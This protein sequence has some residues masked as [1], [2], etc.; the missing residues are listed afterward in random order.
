VAAKVLAGSHGDRKDGRNGAA[1]T[2]QRPS[3]TLLPMT[4]ASLAAP[5]SRTLS[6]TRG[7]GAPVAWSPAH[8]QTVAVLEGRLTVRLEDGDVQL[9]PGAAAVVPAG[10]E[11]ELVADRAVRFVAVGGETDHEELADALVA[12]PPVHARI[13]SGVLRTLTAAFGPELVYG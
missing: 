3:G 9:G 2:P 1:T 4:T 5:A 13:D 7:L 6:L 11:V 12:A 8:S 10:A